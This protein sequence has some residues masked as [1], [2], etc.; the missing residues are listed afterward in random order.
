MT[1]VKQDD[2]RGTFWDWPVGLIVGGVLLLL[3]AASNGA[4]MG[5]WVGLV[6]AAFG[7]VAL[8]ARRGAFSPRR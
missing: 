3:L 8:L 2:K 6:M 5:M 7:L 1:D 4:T